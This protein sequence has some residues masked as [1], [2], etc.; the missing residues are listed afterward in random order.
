MKRVLIM[1]NK[2]GGRTETVTDANE[3]NNPY[4][5]MWDDSL[6]SID[7]YVELSEGNRIQVGTVYNPI[8]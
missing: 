7:F 4:E 2:C 3:N 8:V 1:V 5:I 6:E